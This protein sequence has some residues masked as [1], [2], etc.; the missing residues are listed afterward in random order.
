MVAGY[1]WFGDAPEVEC[2]VVVGTREI[3]SCQLVL[4]D[5]LENPQHTL[6][7]EVQVGDETNSLAHLNRNAG[8]VF[9]TDLNIL[10]YRGRVLDDTDKVEVVGT[11]TSSTTTQD[12]TEE[13][14]VMGPDGNPVSESVVV[15]TVTVTDCK[16]SV[17]EIYPAP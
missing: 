15:D 10:D 3:V 14:L 12:V 1:L 2:M 17:E 6:R 13:R 11:I 7:V 16:L 5:A 9:A 8:A 4:Q